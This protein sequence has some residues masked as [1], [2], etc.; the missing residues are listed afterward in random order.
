MSLWKAV[1]MGATTVALSGCLGGGSSEAPQS[2]DDISGPITFTLLNAGFTADEDDALATTYA[3]PP[4]SDGTI[5][6]DTDEVLDAET[7]EIVTDWGSVTVVDY[8]HGDWDVLFPYT[9][10]HTEGGEFVA[11][12]DSYQGIF[13]FTAM[14]SNYSAFGVWM[15]AE[16]GDLANDAGRIHFAAGAFGFE[17]ATDDMP[18]IGSADYAGAMTGAAVDTRDENNIGVY[19]LAGRADLQVSFGTGTVTGGFW[20]MRALDMIDGDGVTDTGWAAGME[21]GGTFSIAGNRFDGNVDVV[22]GDDNVLATGSLLGGFYG[23]R[24]E[25]AAGTWRASGTGLEF[26]GSFGARD[27][28]TIPPQDPQ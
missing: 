12:D 17:T 7:G 15:V 25:H 1:L 11:S 19:H 23:P 6:L 10:Y 26:V 24:A 3:L 8:L 13:Y 22:D 27:R 2:F 16:D 21:V 5:T 4:N 28:S 9:D 20:D 18:S 14:D